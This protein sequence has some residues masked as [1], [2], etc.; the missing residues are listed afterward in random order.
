MATD[1]IRRDRWGVSLSLPSSPYI[2][3]CLDRREHTV[4]PEFVRAELVR[5]GAV[6]RYRD[7]VAVFPFPVFPDEDLWRSR[8]RIRGIA[9]GLGSTDALDSM[10]SYRM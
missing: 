4:D 6:W 5:V 8:S 9:T 2:L 1:G 7:S 10:E 3:H